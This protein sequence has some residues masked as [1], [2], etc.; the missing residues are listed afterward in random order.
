MIQIND[1]NNPREQGAPIW[2]LPFRTFFLGAAASSCISLLLWVAQLMQWITLPNSGL[3]LL[4]WHGHEMIFGFASLV[5][6]GFALTAVQTWTGLTS[7]YGRS[8]QLLFGLW[9]IARIGIWVNTAESIWLGFVAQIAW[10]LLAI[11]YLSDILLRAKNRRNYL[12]IPMLFG[13]MSLNAAVFL[14]DIND[15]SHY[16]AHL[17]RTAVVAFT[18][19]IGIVGGRVIPF[20]TV[21]GAQT[22]PI[23]PMPWLDN[24]T[25]GIAISAVLVFALQIVVDTPELAAAVLALSGVLHIARMSRWRSL[26]TLSVPLL[27]TLHLAYKSVGVGLIVIAY[28][29]LTKAIPVSIGLHVITVGG[30]GLMILSMMSRVSLGHTGRPL[31]PKPII[32]GAF[33]LLSTALLARVL[34]PLFDFAMVG[35]ISSATLWVLGYA[36]FIAVYWRILSAPKY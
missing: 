29:V 11:Y 32:T 21:R 3:S 22:Q 6:V 18:L 23:K 9:I 27:W 30:I 35:W 4:V 16:A 33:L 31:Q 24:L 36:I 20:F 26:K 28:S 10:W 7:L 2:H 1:P 14:L 25:I 13:L 8:V 19:L 17:L 5:A 34:L 12:F 15:M